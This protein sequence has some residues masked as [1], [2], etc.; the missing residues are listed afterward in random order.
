LDGADGAAD[1]VV[2]NATDSD[3]TIF[4]LSSGG[5]ITVVG[6]LGDDHDHWS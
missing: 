4:V 6:S 2:I 1:T 3:D 5:V